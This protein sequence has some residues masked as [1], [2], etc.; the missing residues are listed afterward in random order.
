M[1]FAGK[2]ASSARAFAVLRLAGTRACDAFEG[3]LGAAGDAPDHGRL[4]VRFPA[5]P[6]LSWLV[7]LRRRTSA[8]RL[9][10]AR[11]SK[12][13]VGCRRDPFRSPPDGAV[14]VEPGSEWIERFVWKQ[15]QKANGAVGEEPWR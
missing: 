14:T 1:P 15:R 7:G 5:T 6:A 8:G 4:G 11:L 10:A 12:L 13:R 9:R 3:E 2:A